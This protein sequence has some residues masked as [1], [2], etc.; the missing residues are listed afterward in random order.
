MCW[1]STPGYQCRSCAQMQVALHLD[2]AIQTLP[3]ALRAKGRDVPANKLALA[4]ATAG[5]K[6][7]NRQHEHRAFLVWFVNNFLTYHERCLALVHTDDGQD[8]FDYVVPVP[9]TR[10]I[11]VHPLARVLGEVEGVRDRLLSALEFTGVGVPHRPHRDKFRVMD[12]RVA[13]AKVM[14]IDDTMT[15]GATVFSAASA[16][17]AAGAH[18]EV[19]VIGRHFDPAWNA[20]TAAFFE[21]AAQIPFD[22]GHCVYCAPGR[23]S[24]RNQ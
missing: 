2:P 20:G 7:G 24:V 18:V 16:L 11:G 22:F 8:H 3:M 14:L 23:R 10:R 9:S 12:S 13:G 6:Y 17:R 19:T 21:S 15:T 5:Y 4:N 1:Q